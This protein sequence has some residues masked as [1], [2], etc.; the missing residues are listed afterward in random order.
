MRVLLDTAIFVYAVGGEH[1]YRDP[2]R[3]IVEQAGARA[4]TATITAD[5]LQEFVHQRTRRGAPRGEAVR[6]AA[7]IPAACAVLDVR[8][9]DATAA[10]ELFEH[11]PE[12][13]ARDAI[14][15]AVALG[16]GVRHILS[17]DRAF[18]VVGGLTRVDPRDRD[19]V[20]A[21]VT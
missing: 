7:R 11:H 14:V 3:S 1:A 15:A 10:L 21:L 19:G 5:L 8:L 13:D 17:P 20:A 6:Q 4:F 2:C 18:D 12:L 16:R 9:A